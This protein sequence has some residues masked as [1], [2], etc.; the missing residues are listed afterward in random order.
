MARGSLSGTRG[1]PW[2]RAIL[3]KSARMYKPLVFSVAGGLFLFAMSDRKGN[4][5][6][7]ATRPKIRQSAA[8]S[9]PEHARR[10]TEERRR[11]GRSSYRHSVLLNLFGWRVEISKVDKNK[12]GETMM[13]RER[14]AYGERSLQERSKERTAAACSRRSI[15]A[16]TGEHEQK[17]SQEVVSESLLVRR[18]GLFHSF[19]LSHPV[20]FMMPPRKKG[21]S[22]MLASHTPSER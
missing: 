2:W 12:G 8:G 14:L 21:R 18:L 7:D 4:K 1:V 17:K 9:R 19:S 3:A 10:S 5:M 6:F 15:T 13:E 22:V 16:S 20:A 11:R